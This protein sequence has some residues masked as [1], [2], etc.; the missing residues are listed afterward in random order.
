MGPNR[1]EMTYVTK[2]NREDSFAMMKAVAIP[3]IV[4]GL[5]IFTISSFAAFGTKII[6]P[7]S[8]IMWIVG[9]VVAL[10]MPP[11]RTEVLRQ[12]MMMCS[13]YC[14]TLMGLKLALGLVSGAS[15]EMIAASYGQAIPT[16]TG[17]TLPGIVQ[18]ILWYSSFGR[19]RHHA[20]KESDPIQ[21]QE[22]PA[23]Y[24]SEG[25]G[26]QQRRQGKHSVLEMKLVAVIAFSLCFSTN[27]LLDG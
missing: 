24:V 25:Q 12:T 22:E 1:A 27:T 19:I 14:L 6:S 2:T 4:F 11:E 21:P 23:G 3:A 7:A 18:N 9:F 15:S 17:N 10:L 16:T 5:E 20:G 26:D 8:A 13:I